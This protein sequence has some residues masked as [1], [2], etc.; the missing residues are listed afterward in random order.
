[1]ARALQKL[2]DVLVKSAKL[3][4]GRHSDGGGLYLNVTPTGSKS[5]LFMWT[6]GRKR[7]EMGL[8]P[9]PALSL[10][11]ARVK[12]GEAREAVAEGRDPIAEKAKE[13]EPTFAECVEK[14][15]GS[16]EG[17]WRND[18]HRAQWRMTLGDAYCKPIS[19][20]RVSQIGTDELLRVLSPIWNEK[21]ETAS[22]IRGRIERVLDFAKAKGW[23]EGENPALWRGHLKS[24]LPA[25]QKLQRGHHAAM[26]YGGMP[27]FMACLRE[28]DGTAARALE[29]AILNASRSG[30]VLGA[31]WDEIDDHAK[32]WTIPKERMKAGRAHVV[33]LSDAALSILT[34]MKEVAVG[35]YVFPGA[36]PKRPLSNMAMTAVMRRLKLG[37]LTVH[38]FRSTFR[39]WCGD[40]TTFPRD[41]AE[42]ALAH[43][44]GNATEQAYR[45]ADA[46]EKRRRL[47]VAW[48][49]FLESKA[50]GNVITLT[51]K[52]NG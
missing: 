11:K 43:R 51:R 14:F 26:D 34:C 45:R 52:A 25:R 17:Q 36:K 22:R 39:D 15:L 12:A 6:V 21:N 49:K 40:K 18:K 38:G 31:R 8:G 37:H 50:S 10:A 42:M 7:R 32:T 28:A 1:M 44:V 27:A 48:S 20:K 33:P 19:S 23:R 2:S 46:L 29:F 16:M 4:P 5:W 41:V 9:Y 13:D 30:E 24:L 47:L 35:D 3:K